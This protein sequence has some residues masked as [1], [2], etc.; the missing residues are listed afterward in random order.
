MILANDIK[1]YYFSQ[2]STLP[3]DIQFHFCSRLNAWEDSQLA[4]RRLDELESYMFPHGRSPEGLAAALRAIANH[5]HNKPVYAAETRQKY[6]DAYPDLKALGLALFRVRHWQIVYQVDGLDALLTI[7]PKEQITELWQ[8]LCQ[9]H[10]AITGLSTHAINF[11]YLCQI[12]GVVDDDLPIASHIYPADNSDDTSNSGDELILKIYLYTHCII[13]DTNFYARPVSQ[14]AREIYVRMLEEI[15]DLITH[16]FGSIKL[17]AKLEF[18]VCS[19]IVGRQP[20]IEHDIYRECE[21]SV[22][23]KGTF[24][25]DV[26]NRYNGRSQD[27]LSG[28]EHRNVLFIMSRTPYPH[29]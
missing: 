28:S 19:R 8:S 5:A 26:M 25:I 11:L 7:W 29:I 16:N 12:L 17:D 23:P 1:N 14:E 4:R 10:E 27:T 22:S 18:L 13:A 3:T 15:Q 20:N 9:D 24:L 6:F 21:Q 2:L